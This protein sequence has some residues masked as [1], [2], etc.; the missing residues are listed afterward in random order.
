MLD[1]HTGVRGRKEAEKSER[2]AN[3]DENGEW[4]ARGSRGPSSL[5]RSSQFRI[6]DLVFAER[7]FRHFHYRFEWY[8]G[9]VGEPGSVFGGGIEEFG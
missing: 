1:S 4:N 5:F 3:D 8:R 7:L 9:Q 2:K 6:S